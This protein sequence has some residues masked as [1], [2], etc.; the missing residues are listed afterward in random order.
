MKALVLTGTKQME[1]QDLDTPTPKPDEVLVK[2][3]YAGICGTDDALYNGLPGSAD[4]VPPIV[5]G[6]ENSGVVAAVGANVTQFKKGDRVA[7]DPN[8]YFPKDKYFRVDRPQLAESLSAVGVTRD[9]GLEE[10]F[11]APESVVYHVPAN[12]SLK[13]ACSTEPVSC[14]VHGIRRLSLQPHYKA[15]VMG[16]G[17]MGLLFVEL[18]KAYG[19]QHVD[20]TGRHD[21]KLAE[22]QKLTGADHVINTESGDITEEY[23]IVIEAVGRPETQEK[24]I[25]VAGKGGQ[26]LMFGVGRPDQTFTVNTYEVFQKELDIKGSFINPYS[27]DDSLALMASGKIDVEP[28]I[29]NVLQLDEVVGKLDGSDKRPGKSVV[30]LDGSLK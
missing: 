5:L 25:E 20:L 26:I 29:K 24:A 27:F 1:I 30:E 18:L 4:A 17:Y 15:L 23:D 28:L 13:A 3:A 9:G 7:V 12:L 22:E 16:D 6:H 21:D 8:I 2:T 11:T 14:G 10:Y 19:V